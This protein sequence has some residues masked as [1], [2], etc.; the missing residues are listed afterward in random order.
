MPSA[1]L[2]VIRLSNPSAAARGM[3]DH[4]RVSYRLVRLPPGMH[5]LLLRL[6]GFPR[7][8]VPAL[9]IDGRRL[10]GSLDISRALDELR[11]DP[12]LFPSD[13][14]LRARVEA[15]ERWGEAELQEIP[16]RAFRFALTQ[17][18]ELRRW[19]SEE[20]IG[21][22]APGLLADAGLPVIR[23]LAAGADEERV[24]G[25]RERLPGLL[26]R[27]D[28]LIAEG[29]IGGDVPN[30]ADF[31]VLSTVRVLLESSEA[32]RAVDGRPCE[33][34]ARRLFPDW[35]GGPIPS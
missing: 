2:Y 24:Q 5:P 34:A 21:L 28:E 20:I 9:E 13:P 1:R 35:D 14:E 30:A 19:L 6:A 7:G 26:D 15:A 29:T 33:A 18:R 3:L 22:P 4:K 11:P 8:T 16:R 25:D 17:D 31:Q 23:L 27:V 10:Q 32:A 12:P